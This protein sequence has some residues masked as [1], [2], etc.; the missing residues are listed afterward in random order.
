MFDIPELLIADWLTVA[1]VAAC[2]AS[3]LDPSNNAS[4]TEITRAGLSLAKESIAET[5]FLSV[6]LVVATGGDFQRIVHKNLEE[7]VVR[8]LSSRILDT[9]SANCR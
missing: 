6:A 7:I 8:E 5:I 9:I 4:A 3:T 2:A 1:T